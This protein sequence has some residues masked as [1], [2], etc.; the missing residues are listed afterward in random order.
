MKSTVPFVSV[1]FV[2]LQVLL[3]GCT[4]PAGSDSGGPGSLEKPTLSVPSGTIGSLTLVSITCPGSG[5]QI[6]YTTDGSVPSNSHGEFYSTPVEV[7]KSQTLRAVATRT[8]F[9]DSPLAEAEYIVTSGSCGAP[10]EGIPNRK[11][12]TALV[13]VNTLRMAPQ[14][15]KTAYAGY[16]AGTVG[17]SM[18]PPT[19]P[20]YPNHNLG[21]AARA[22]SE[23]MQSMGMMTFD[24]SAAKAALYGGASF[25][26]RR[27]YFA[28]GTIWCGENI[29]T[30]IAPPR[31]AVVAW[32]YDMS[33]EDT[34]EF[35]VYTGNR[36]N[37]C[38]SYA[39]QAGLGCSGNW[40]TY[41]SIRD[42]PNYSAPIPSAGHDTGL[43]TGNISFLLNYYDT[44]GGDP[45]KVL[46]SLDGVYIPMNLDI[47][48]GSRGTYRI[49]IPMASY[50]RRYFFL[51]AKADGSLWRYPG[52]GCYLT[53]ED[54]GL[55]D[56]EP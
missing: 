25:T 15:F 35:D 46:L 32:L 7:Y 17:L 3:S 29:L 1:L 48:T 36:W 50:S 13:Y 33:R 43:S 12:R 19:H 53:G 22:H 51:T 6:R 9:D 49:D 26:K 52:S 55:T 8:G 23:D 31:P 27:E 40:W 42:N 16:S 47:G 41:D 38:I 30:G 2:V 11:E 10:L 21:R 54:G 4:N 44:E 24:S 18:F 45:L 5:I 37:L 14:A 28:P 20:L 34:Y 39:K 56:Y